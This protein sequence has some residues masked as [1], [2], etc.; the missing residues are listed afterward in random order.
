MIGL[1]VGI[2]YALFIV[3]RYRQ[4]LHEGR[5]PREATVVAY[6]TAGRAVLFAGGTVLISLLGL[7]VVGLPFMD[8]SRGRSDRR[9]AHGPGRGPDPLARHA[10]LRGSG[11]RPLARPGLAGPGANGR[12]RASGTA[13]A[14]RCSAARGSAGS[15]AL[16][17]LVVLAL[18]LFSMRLAFSDAGN[19]PPG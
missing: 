2:D 15:A 10:R 8:G 9:R 6:S 17:V 14:G 12:P 3:T 13:G 19:D 18:P 4:G 7:F 5:D 11:H 1:G 16:L